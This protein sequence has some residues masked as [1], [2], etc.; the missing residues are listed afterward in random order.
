MR[1]YISGKMTGLKNYREVFQKHEDLL[2]SWGYTDIVNPV[3]LS[4]KIIEKYNMT[5]EES[6]RPENAKIFLTEDL[7]VLLDC[8]ILY[9]IPNWHTSKGANLEKHVAERIGKLILFGKED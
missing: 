7:R 6:F 8:D 4:D 3:H 2:R 9:L 1:V 5:E